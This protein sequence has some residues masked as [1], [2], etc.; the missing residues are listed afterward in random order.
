MKKVQGKK[1]IAEI[2]NYS[3]GRIVVGAPRSK[4]FTLLARHPIGGGMWMG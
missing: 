4:G 2:K 1:Y 3:T